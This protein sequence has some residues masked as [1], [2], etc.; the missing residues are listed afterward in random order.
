MLG[1]RRSMAESLCCENSLADLY[2]WRQQSIWCYPEIP[3][4]GALQGFPE[5]VTESWLFRANARSLPVP[6]IADRDDT[7]VR[8]GNYH[9]P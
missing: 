3:I 2:I 1:V 5:L 8:E 4:L 6:E 7:I 9:R